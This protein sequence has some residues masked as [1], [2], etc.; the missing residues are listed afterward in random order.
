M[1]EWLGG[2]EADFPVTVVIIGCFAATGEHSLGA[3]SPVKPFAC[4]IFAD[5]HFIALRSDDPC[6]TVEGTFR[7]VP[8]SQPQQ[9]VAEQGFKPRVAW[10]QVW[11]LDHRT[12]ELSCHEKSWHW[13]MHFSYKILAFVNLSL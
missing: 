13:V 8:H 5:G 6:L 4:I 9:R 1:A 2:T 12:T 10:L 7:V 11:V 3:R